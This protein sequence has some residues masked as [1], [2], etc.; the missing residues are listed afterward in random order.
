MFIGFKVFPDQVRLVTVVTDLHQDFIIDR[1]LVV[2][3]YDPLRRLPTFMLINVVPW[4]ASDL[5]NRVSGVWVSR[6][7]AFQHVTPLWAHMVRD[8][9]IPIHDFFVEHLCVLVIKRQISY[10]A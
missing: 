8:A 7:N 6:Q 2:A 5:R 1:N 9:E 10:R 3:N 4:V